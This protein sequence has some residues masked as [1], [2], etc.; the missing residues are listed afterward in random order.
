MALALV[1]VGF[2]APGWYGALI[3]FVLVVA[4]AVRMSR[5][6]RYTD[7]RTVVVRLAILAGIA[8][9]AVYKVL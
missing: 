7:R 1:L 5:T 6:A 2:F 4:L 9:I 8:A 3:L